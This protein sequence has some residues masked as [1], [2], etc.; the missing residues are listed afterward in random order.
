MKTG[1]TITELAAELARQAENK[2][3]FLA[4]TSKLTMQSDVMN[5]VGSD[6][7]VEVVTL[8]GLGEEPLPLT[9]YAH[10]QVAKEVDIP[11][12]YYDRML[13]DA[14]ALLAQNVNLWFHRNPARRLVR[15]LDDRVRGFLSDKFRPLDNLDLAEA[16]LPVLLNRGCVIVSA[17]VTEKRLYIKAINPTM[18]EEVKGSKVVGDV[19]R[20]GIVFSNSE[21]GAGR[22]QIEDFI[23]RLW[24]LNGMITTSTFTKLHLGRAYGEERVRELLTSDTRRQNDK[25]FW[26]TVRDVVGNAFSE[27]SFKATAA[28]FSRTT[29]TFIEGDPDK[30]LDKVQE[31]FSFTDGTR[32]NILRHLISNGDLSQWGLANAVTRAAEDEASYDD[33]TD[34]ERM[35]GQIIE[36]KPTDWATIQ[37]AA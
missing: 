13:V 17:E 3:D 18:K 36:L 37:K 24:C 16:A 19:I 31:L 27:E 14:P 30:A 22:L 7:H 9:G 8:A 23:D 33:A 25:A 20:A 21:I 35:G 28:R 11:K 6:K 1:K 34:L 26:M 12:K 2:R 5:E 32:G 4:S 29:Q 15:T 10:G